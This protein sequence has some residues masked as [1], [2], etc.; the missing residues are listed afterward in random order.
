MGNK[1]GRRERGLRPNR[2]LLPSAAMIVILG[3][4][5]SA[6]YGGAGLEWLGR[7]RLGGSMAVGMNR[8]DKR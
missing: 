3:R 7:H 8:R 2:T 4:E 5:T 6:Q 1:R